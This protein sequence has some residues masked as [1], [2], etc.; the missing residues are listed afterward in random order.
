MTRVAYLSASS[1]KG[2][3]SDSEPAQPMGGYF[4]AHCGH[5]SIIPSKV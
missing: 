1:P 3:T 4:P 2:R 5:P